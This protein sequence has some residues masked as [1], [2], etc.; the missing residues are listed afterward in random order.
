MREIGVT[1]AGRLNLSLW[2]KLLGL[3][4]WGTLGRLAKS[5]RLINKAR[6]RS[7]TNPHEAIRLYTRAIDILS[8]TVGRD[9]ERRSLLGP[10]L[11]ALGK[12]QEATGNRSGA[13]GSYLRAKNYLQSLPKPVL[14]FVA[15]ELARQGDKRAGSIS[16][17]LEF[18]RSFKDRK[19][20][21]AIQ[22]V[23]DLLEECCAVRENADPKE[24]QER[25]TLCKQIIQA[26]PGLE[27]AH[28][29]A[30][31]IHFSGKR[32]AEAASYFQRAKALR[33]EKP[34]LDFYHSFS[35]GMLLA[36]AGK[37]EAA[38]E[39]RQAVKWAPER[40]DA[41]FTLGKSLV[42]LCQAA[43]IKPKGDSE[44]VAEAI[45]SL[46]QAVRLDSNRAEYA[47]YLGQAYV[48]AGNIS[49]AARSFEQ[50]TRLDNKNAEYFFHLGK[51]LK[52]LGSTEPARGAAR[53]ALALDERYMPA[54]RLLAEICL[55]S[56]GFHE[57][58]REFQ[59]VLSSDPKDQEVR[60]KFG[61]AL[62]MLKQFTEAI[63]ILEPIRPQSDRAAFYIARCYA[64]L[65]RFEDAA[66]LLN[67]LATRQSSARVFY[68]LALARAHLGQFAEAVESFG[69][70]ISANGAQAAFY[71]QRAHAYIK[72]GSPAE[73]RAD[74]EKA[75][76][77]HPDD[78][79]ILFHLGCVCRMLE[80]DEA[81][82]AC[83][84]KAV[85]LDPTHVLASLELGALYEK[86]NRVEESLREYSIAAKA[87]PNNPAVHRRTGVLL[88]RQRDYEG[89]WQRLQQ[90]SALG[91]DSD[92]TLYYAGL[93][94]ANR[95][96]FQTALQV[97]GRLFERHRE[98]KRL[99]LNLNRLHY[100][101][102]KQHIEAGRLKEAVEEWET[103]LKP[104]PE[105]EELKKEIAKLHF[106][107]ALDELARN[108]ASASTDGKAIL[109]RA[110]AL[111][112]ENPL[113]RYYHALC[114]LAGG[115]FDAYIASA[116]SLL[117]RLDS[118]TQLH[119]KYHLGVAWL[120]KKEPEKAEPLLREVLA[121]AGRAGLE[122]D[123]SLPLAAAQAEAG[124]LEEAINL[125]TAVAAKF[126]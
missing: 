30:G 117:H 54:H 98:D 111:D 41:H 68:Y 46:E 51:A 73:A 14:S 5:D 115:Q 10:A 7:A 26:D 6:S 88:C 48:L 116:Q 52:A 126:A 17:Y 58:A 94:A 40:A 56:K 65:D 82:T 49:Q 15:V 118:R 50:A 113:Y 60:E 62:F 70:A 79:S 55:E 18:I 12:S 3:F 24:A 124:R 104:R 67:G 69:K 107:L 112:G 95:G 20:T 36:Q 42:G 66:E 72:L 77:L 93:V 125:L 22:Q 103:Y 87:D 110:L 2:A 35:D 44:W 96:D 33:S 16:I 74:Y 86:G 8:S 101:I 75:L 63:K 45:A 76:E 13:L 114:N 122:L 59:I 105:D 61:F 83:L 106:R 57:A 34:R 109:E 11:L 1:D 71:V 4:G 47:Y 21:P 39:F 89:A 100:L 91:D 81:A 27:W 123:A 32:Y 85:S 84:S 80:D 78:V 121:E 92:E 25:L 31:I 19:K 108:S 29:Y 53:S 97:W 28:Y 90:A 23:Y 43:A 99:A 38:A 64:H 119:A 120:A 9:R 102:G 37:L